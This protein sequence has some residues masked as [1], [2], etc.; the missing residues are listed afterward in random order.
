MTTVKDF[1]ESRLYQLA[2]KKMQLEKNVEYIYK[3]KNFKVAKEEFDE[4]ILEGLLL[5]LEANKRHVKI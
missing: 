2:F 3:S 5:I 1:R 4:V